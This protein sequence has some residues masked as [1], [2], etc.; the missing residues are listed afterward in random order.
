MGNPAGGRLFPR[1]EVVEDIPM[2][3]RWFIDRAN[4]LNGNQLLGI[5]RILDKAMNN[6]SVILL[7]EVGGKS[8]CFPA[9]R[10]SRIGRLR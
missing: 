2:Q 5:V 3:T 6:T 4:R 1:A 9:M 7:F 10:R 8:C